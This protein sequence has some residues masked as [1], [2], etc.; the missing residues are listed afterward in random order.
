M[1]F[2]RI[3][4]KILNTGLRWSLLTLTVRVKKMLFW[5][6]QWLQTQVVSI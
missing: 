6:S 5:E 4:Q 1:N 3:Y 2:H